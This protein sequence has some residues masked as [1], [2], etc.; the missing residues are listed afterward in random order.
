MEVGQT[1]DHKKLQ[2]QLIWFLEE[3]ICSGDIRRGLITVCA[4]RKKGNHEALWPETFF[5]PGNSF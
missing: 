5:D 1:S 3:T 4:N 2:M